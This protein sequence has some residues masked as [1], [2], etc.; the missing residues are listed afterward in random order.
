MRDWFVKPLLIVV[1]IV[2]LIG[3]ASLWWLNA[4]PSPAGA[5]EKTPVTAYHERIEQA[6]RD[7]ENGH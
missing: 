5:S 2:V 4:G 6:L 7:A 3:A 1:A